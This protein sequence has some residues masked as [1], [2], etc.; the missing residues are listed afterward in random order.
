MTVEYY[1]SLE[2]QIRT[3][4]DVL[5]LGENYEGG[6]PCSTIVINGERLELHCWRVDTSHDGCGIHYEGRKGHNIAKLIKPLL[7]EMNW[8]GEW[9]I[10]EG[11]RR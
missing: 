1:K 5:A 10:V 9:A 8:Y 3:G 11:Y 2:G 6:C 4:Y 7:D